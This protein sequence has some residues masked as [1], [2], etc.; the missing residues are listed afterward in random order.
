MGRAA[1]VPPSARWLLVA[2]VAGGILVASVLPR[3]T[4]VTPPPGPGPVGVVGAD[5]WLHA[6]AYAGLAGTLLYALAPTGRSTLTVVTIVLGLAA[7]FGLAV[8]LIQV[9]LPT[10]RF[11]PL[12]AAANA[13]GATAAIV[14]R[15]AV[16]E[17]LGARSPRGAA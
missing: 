1:R 15:W 8:E 3:S 16:A 5:K 11:E 17:L 14:V 6:L 7:A 10:R 12:D 9:P 4:G 2:L 13:V